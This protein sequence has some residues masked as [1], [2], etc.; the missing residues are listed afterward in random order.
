MKLIPASNAASTHARACSRATPPAYVSQDPRL[1][2]DTEISLAPSL[3]N[4]TMASLSA[5]RLH[6]RRGVVACNGGDASTHRSQAQDQRRALG[7]LGARAQHRLLCAS[8]RAGAD[9]AR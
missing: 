8:A 4:C 3:R 5:A 2:S 9:L 6:G 7:R 1:I